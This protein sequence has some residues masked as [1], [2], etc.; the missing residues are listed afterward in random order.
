MDEIFREWDGQETPGCA[1]GVVAGGDLAFSRGYGMANLEYGVRIQ[2]D[3]V[4]H[5]ASVSK[6][7]TAWCVCLL[8]IDLEA[9]ARRWLPELPASVTVRQMLAH[10]SGLRD[11]WDLL[12]MAGWRADDLKTNEDVLELVRGQRALNF[13][14]GS[15]HLYSNTG[16]TLAGILVERVSGRSL[17]EFARERIF[18]PLGMT[19]THFHDDH[20][21][22]VPGRAYG[23]EPGLKISIPAF[24]T[25][26][27]TSLFTTVEDLAKWVTQ[28]PAPLAEPVVPSYG[29][30]LRLGTH[31]GMPTIGHSGADAGYRSHVL[32]LPEREL[33]VIVLCNLSTMKPGVLALRV[34]ER[35]LGLAPLPDLPPAALPPGLYR[36]PE[37]A[38]ARRIEG[39]EIS[40]ELGGHWTLREAGPGRYMY[41]DYGAEVEVTF[42]GA[43]RE[44]STVY[45]P[46]EPWKP[47]SVEVYAGAYTSTEL[48]VTWEL[49]AGGGALIV[50]RRKFPD[51]ILRPT[52]AGAFTD[53]RMHLVFRDG[54]LDVSTVRVRRLAFTRARP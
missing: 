27:A 16:F 26:G 50:R 15:E 51:R 39:T 45:S 11:Q 46:V 2:P 41:G 53:G 8:G 54:G 24:D 42:D 14:P 22:I 6:Q 40:D 7:F 13:A 20:R 23:Y 34:A 37:T 43:L 36:N 4:F 44:G 33:G 38:L 48:G 10:T 3:S 18:G 19:R 31:G 12:S 21:E 28:I 5:V 25:V 1:V 35:W 17:R 52:A 29:L 49:V 30:G 47:D 32:W 9:D